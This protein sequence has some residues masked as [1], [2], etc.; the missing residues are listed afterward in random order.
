MSRSFARL[1]L[2]AGAVFGL[3]GP[4]GAG[5]TTAV[6]ILTTVIEPDAGTA[7]VLGHDVVADPFAVRS[8]IGL[9]GQFAAVDPNLT[10]MENLWMVGRLAQLPNPRIRPRAAEL[11][12]RFDL[13]EAANRP[14]RTYSGGMR[15]RLDVAAA[16][17]QKPPVLFLDEPTTGLDLQSRNAL[18]GL[19][20]ELVADGTTVLL[21]TQYLEEAD[22]LAD[23]VAVIDRGKVVAND[24]PRALKSSLG[25][26]VMEIGFPSETKARQA[27][28]VLAAGDGESPEREGAA[29]RLSSN[30]GASAL[31][32]ILRTLDG[33]KLK[34]ASLAV[35]EPSLDD[36]FLALTGHKAEAAEEEEAQEEPAQGRRRRRR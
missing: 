29:I 8:S 10:G 14:V 28:K 12:E 34:P 36:V 2:A 18:W 21:T 24:T 15:R 4:N 30:D 31:V 5:K 6:R 9:A 19:I 7:E 16:L 35:R 11:L 32:D 20:G 22:R 27:Q 1:A 13:S 17:V 26:T 25:S 23:R 3:L 33:K